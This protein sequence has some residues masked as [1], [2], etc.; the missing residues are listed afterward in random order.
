MC[1]FY[2]NINKLLSNY[3]ALFIQRMIN[4]TDGFGSFLFDSCLKIIYDKTRNSLLK[5][6]GSYINI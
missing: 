5:E 3:V 1:L 2:P 6:R 4:V